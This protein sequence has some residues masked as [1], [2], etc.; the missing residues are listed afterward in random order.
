MQ[1]QLLETWWLVLV[2]VAVSL[3]LL[4]LLP[5]SLWARALVTDPRTMMMGPLRLPAHDRAGPGPVGC[6]QPTSGIHRGHGPT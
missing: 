6:G 1:L 4:L 5:L 2:L 3:S